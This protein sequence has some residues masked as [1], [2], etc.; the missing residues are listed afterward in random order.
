MTDKLPP[1][2]AI[3][4]AVVADTTDG[5]RC[6]EG[7]V[8][9]RRRKLKAIYGDGSESKP[10]PYDEAW[11]EA[12]DAVALVVHYADAKGERRVFLR[13][14]MRPPAMFRPKEICPIPESETLGHLWEIPAGL[15]EKN[16][17]SEEGLRSC[18]S[19]ELKEELGFEVPKERIEKLGPALFPTP[20]LIGER[21]FFF[22]VEVDPATRKKPEEDGALEQ[23]ANIADLSLTDAIELCRTGAIEDMKTEVGLRRLA[24]RF[25]R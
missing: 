9:V 11:R 7:F 10:F 15:L 17:R 1:F 2:P 18:S 23:G 16:E 19:R 6:D 12:M 14:A 24:D 21:V 8:R 20:G 13:S 22:H 4:L 3:R 5:S 25:P